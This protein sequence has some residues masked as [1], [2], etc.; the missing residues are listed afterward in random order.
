M[1]I[2]NLHTHSEFT[3]LGS[4][5]KV[6]RI[7]GLSGYHGYKAVAISD[8][9]STYGF[10]K[11]TNYCELENLK[12]IYGIELYFRTK[13]KHSF[14]I[15]LYAKNEKGLKN[16]FQLNTIAQINFSRTRKYT[17]DFKLLNEYKEGLIALVEEEIIYYRNDFKMLKELIEQYKK[18]FEENFYVE[19]NFTGQRKVP[20]IRELI[21]IIENFNLKAI[22]TCET[23]YEREDKNAFEFLSAFREKSFSKNE[24]GIKFVVDYDYSFRTKEEF[25]TIFK[26]HPDYISNLE[27]LISMI[28][29]KIDLKTPKLFKISKYEDLKDICEQ[30]LSLFLVEKGK[31]NEKI[32]RERLEK[33][34][35]IIKE[36]G[37]EDFFLFS[38]E[39]ANFL[40]RKGV[41]FGP[42]R[43]SSASS[44]VLFLLG[45]IRVD[46]VK[47]KLLFERFLNP[48]RIETPDIDIDV[49]WKK[50]AILFNYLFDKYRGRVA[51]IAT[52][53]RLLPNALINEI[54]K[55]FKLKK[56]KVKFI[57]RFFYRSNISIY[58]ALQTEEKLMRS[59]IEEK[60]IREFLDI[61]MKIEA[62]PQHSSVHS[63]GILIT[64]EDIRNYVSVEIARNGN[65][66][67]QITKED[68]ESTGF[69]KLDILGLRFVTIINE[70][71]RKVKIDK[72]TLRDKRTFELI[73]TGDTTGVFQLESAGM[74]ELLKKV[75]PKTI[76]EL[77]DVIA[78]YRPG[79]LRSG[80][81]DEYCEI[82]FREK[83]EKNHNWLKGLLSD[84]GGIFIY[85]EQILSLANDIAGFDWEKTD[86]FRKALSN[87][88]TATIISLKEDFIS[89]CIKNNISKE[90]ANHL[91]G[92]IV[93]FGAYSFNKAHSIS[94][95]YNAYI[96]AYLKLHYPL[97]F[98]V[99]LLNNYIGFPLKLERYLFEAREKGLKFKP[100]DINKCDVF[101]KDE[102]RDLRPG[103]ILIKYV[104]YNLAK[105]IVLERRERGVYKDII[106]FC[107]RTKRCG[108]SSKSLECLILAGCFDFMGIE[109]TRLV[110]IAPEILKE[111][112]ELQS[113]EAKGINELFPVEEELDIN[114]FINKYPSQNETEIDRMNMEFAATDLHIFTHPLEVVKSRLKDLQLDKLENID[115]QKYLFV[116]AIVEKIRIYNTTKGEKLAIL[117][118]V[119]ETATSNAVVNP[120]IFPSYESVLKR[121]GVYFFKG[122]NSNGRFY[123]DEIYC[124]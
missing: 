114:G 102:G 75:K 8:L 77:S 101:L 76:E 62:L 108:L 80:M 10:Y 90:E 5:L 48:A 105:K 22:P 81:T 120:S 9:F 50:R 15:L 118:L 6:D 11:L 66:V 37:L 7:V 68:V 115:F 94:Y 110:K 20:L 55:V 42:G 89:G 71:M 1:L 78:L 63:G 113:E 30:K 47:Y 88:D 51:H 29:V 18:L 3:F 27:E 43:G 92:V 19:V 106:D 39:I 85:Q 21:S 24:K 35:K 26:N 86:I 56:E 38:Y 104:G 12:P 54:S 72:I 124:I 45:V 36:K 96:T 61:L 14:P 2:A 52:I 33:E 57:K 98:F 109:R 87:K 41:P 83:E 82:R 103:L 93:D 95:A 34:L 84:T 25:L 100:F 59:Y 111:V 23:R 13:E 53:K 31:R 73:S 67:A 97:E 119:D 121:G 117:T 99:S 16:L 79:P 46:P 28:D 44:L 91:F 65:P 17:I 4:T 60:E 58:D 32:Y 112:G 74:R 40:K 107:F 122:K 49:C 64:P 70:T 116:L 123:I 69:I